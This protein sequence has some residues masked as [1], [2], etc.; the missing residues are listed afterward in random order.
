M[1]EYKNQL[2]LQVSLRKGS[3]TEPDLNATPGYESDLDKEIIR[4][5]GKHIKGQNL[6]A[7]FWAY[8]CVNSWEEIQ[9][10]FF[11][12]LNCELDVSTIQRY[13]RNAANRILERIQPS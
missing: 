7:F 8:H 12:H 11:T 4:C 2:R 6:N 5:A 3:V 13:A 1:K 10:K 9:M